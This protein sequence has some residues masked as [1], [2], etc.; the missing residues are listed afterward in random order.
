MIP[1]IKRLER[2]GR[3]VWRIYL[4]AWGMP[5]VERSTKA[6]AEQW[7]RDNGEK[8]AKHGAKGLMDDA[9][10][11]YLLA[12]RDEAAKAGVDIMQAI[13]D[14]KVNGDGVIVDTQL[15]IAWKRFVAAK[16]KAGG[17]EKYLQNINWSIEQLVK[18]FGVDRIVHTI[19]LEEIEEYADSRP[20]K[21]GTR[22]RQMENVRAFFNY[23]KRKHWVRS[24]VMHRMEPIREELTPPAILTVDQCKGLLRECMTNH[25]RLLP[26]LAVQMFAGLRYEECM[27]RLTP[28]HFKSTRAADGTATQGFI[29]LEATDTKMR[30]RRLVPIYEPLQA[31]LDLEPFTE[32][33]DHW[34][35]WAKMKHAVVDPWPHN[36]LRHTS[37][38][39][40]YYKLGAAEAARVLGHAEHVLHSNY[41]GRITD[42]ASVDAF[43][44]LNP[45]AVAVQAPSA[46]APW[47][48]PSPQATSG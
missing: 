4:S 31:W 37:A 24:N 28:E 30:Q 3:T 13:L 16:E 42:L 29:D 27:N 46:P 43:W 10:Y 36:A 41:K 38:T 12:C 21:L 20:W 1:A 6:R 5:P 14:A 40:L 45:E 18:W 26:H 33:N 7:V 15:E 22:R 34:R 35:D 32:V 17:R 23:C 25:R 2:P 48:L 19:T 39:Y 8:L 9:E 44:G 47:P 11:R